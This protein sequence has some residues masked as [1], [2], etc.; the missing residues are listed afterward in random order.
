[1]KT[2]R[3]KTV[4]ISVYHKDG[5][6]VVVNRLHSLGIE[7]ISTGGTYSFI[8]N[9]SNI[10][11]KKVDDITEY[12]DLFDGR[13]KTL[14]PAIM[15]GILYRRNI[16]RDDMQRQKYNIP[17]IDLLIVDLYPFE[18][19]VKSTSVY[20]EII[21]K[22]DIGG[23]SLI[24]AGAKNYADVLVVPS[25]EY[26]NE[27]LEILERRDGEITL[28][29]RK[30]FA[31]YAFQVTSH[32]DT[33]IFNYFNREQC[34]FAFRQSYDKFSKLRYGENPHQEGY[35][36]GD[37]EE[38]F[39]Q[40]HGKEI[41]YNNLQDLEGAVELVYE[42]TEP[43]FVIVKHGNPCG[44]AVRSVVS[45]AWESAFL[46]D[47]LSA[48]GGVVASNRCIDK[49]TAEKM[50]DVFF[51]ILAAPS[52]SEEALSI[53]RSRKNRILL[54]LRDF[55]FNPYTYR[56]CFNGVLYQT[57][58]NIKIDDTSEWKVVTE[59]RIPENLYSSLIF[60]NKIVRHTK[61]NAIVIAGNQMLYGSGMG[62]T[63]RVDA[64]K[65]ALTKAET[66]NHCVKG[67]VLASDAFFPFTDGIELAFKAGIEYIIQPGGSIND[68]EV[69]DF[70]NK[71][72]IAMIF[73]GIRHFKH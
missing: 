69:I 71:N 18:E 65:I 40:H 64:V 53:L 66:F 15:G 17:S 2:K 41:S 36:F 4:L 73:T 44:V 14:H 11:V 21:E 10:P 32:Y 47:S 60:S 31:T 26:Y 42:F 56:S 35:Y 19:T 1:M 63:S 34:S 52:Y 9:L 54:E 22:I 37:I 24:R 25:R 57:R 12:P 13:V 16:D 48:F 33:S 6:E 20:D 43:A 38:L 68:N 67:A 27:F 50:N 3:I 49:E 28:E 58:D 29:E 45:E 70:C 51:E 59:R 46:C 7:I 5:L 72:N 39:V 8:K 55:I 62:Q 23:I 30:R 61:S